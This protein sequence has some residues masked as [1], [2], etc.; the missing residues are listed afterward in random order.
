MLFRQLIVKPLRAR[1]PDWPNSVLG[2]P[3]ADIQSTILE[4]GRADFRI[5]CT[6]SVAGTITAEDRVALYCYMNMRSHFYASLATYAAFK[7]DI[8]PAFGNAEVP[9]FVDL[10]SGPGTSALAFAEHLSGKA[11]FDYA[12][13]DIAQPMLDQA[14]RFFSGAKASGVGMGSLRNYISGSAAH[15][16]IIFNASYLFSSDSFARRT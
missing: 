6:H 9:L 2:V 5:G 13:I 11:S 16:S 14:A 3:Y 4:M 10:G 1:S 15:R 7:L 12:P 8:A